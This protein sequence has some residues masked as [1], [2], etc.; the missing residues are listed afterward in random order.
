MNRDELAAF[1]DR[2]LLAVIATTRRDGAP[3]AVPVWYSYDGERVLI[4]TGR[5]RAWVQHLLRDPRISVTIA[6]ERFPFGAVLISGSATFH[7]GEDWIVDEIRRITA[8]YRPADEAERYIERWSSVGG[9]VVVT[10]ERVRSW[11]GGY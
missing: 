3:H 7:E 1:L 4:W 6:E 9:M 11:G 10:P 5:D 8:R 2:P